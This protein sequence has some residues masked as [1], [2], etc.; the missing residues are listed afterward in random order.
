MFELSGWQNGAGEW[1]LNPAW[2]SSPADILAYMD[3]DLS[4]DLEALGPVLDPIAAGAADIS[5]GPG[6]SCPAPR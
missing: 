4:T 1:A 3:I 5:I 6:G 2:T